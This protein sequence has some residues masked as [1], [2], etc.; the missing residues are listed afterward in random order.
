[1]LRKTIAIL[2]FGIC[3]MWNLSA[4]EGLFITTDYNAPF[5][6][7]LMDNNVAFGANFGFWGIFVASIDMYTNFI[8]GEDAFM[9][10]KE[11]DPTGMY[12]WGLGIQIPLGNF[13]FDFD[14]NKYYNNDDE[15]GFQDFCS[16]YSIGFHVKLTETFG[17]EVY[18]RTMTDFSRES[19]IDHS[20]ELDMVGI[21]AMFFL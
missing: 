12:S 4:E 7:E 18:H 21:G 16:S 11:I 17:M 19:E 8:Y 2:I 15:S 9:H 3:V 14:W 5:D 13:F 10:V 20:E 6:N 1:M